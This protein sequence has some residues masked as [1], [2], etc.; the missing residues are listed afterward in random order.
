MTDTTHTTEDLIENENSVCSDCKEELSADYAVVCGLCQ[1]AELCD[2]CRCEVSG[3]YQT[4]RNEVESMTV[5]PEC[6]DDL[7][8]CADR[9]CGKLGTSDTA[10]YIGDTRYCSETCSAN[11]DICKGCENFVG[12][13]NLRGIHGREATFASDS[14]RYKGHIDT[15]GEY[16]ESCFEDRQ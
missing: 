13:E 9:S 14:G 2:N 6:A 7:F 3:N 5:C 11:A 15:Y 8:S 10:S 1:S 12:K 16:C 4:Y